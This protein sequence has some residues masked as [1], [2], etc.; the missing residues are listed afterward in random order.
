VSA[1]GGPH[2]GEEGVHLA[3]GDPKGQQFHVEK[4]TW[5]GGEAEMRLANVLRRAYGRS[6]RIST[7]RIRRES[8]ASQQRS[9][10]RRSLPGSSSREAL[11]VESK[12]EIVVNSVLNR[13]CTAAGAD[14]ALGSRMYSSSLTLT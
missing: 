6:S 2:R 8:R 13:V 1:Q 4:S 3:G 12:A 5:H 7:P 11:E 9:I 10:I 14:R